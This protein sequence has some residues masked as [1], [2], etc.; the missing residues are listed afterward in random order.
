MTTVEQLAEQTQTQPSGLTIGF[1]EEE[2]LLGARIAKGVPSFDDVLQGKIKNIGTTNFQK[3]RLNNQEYTL[4]E[5]LKLPNGQNILKNKYDSIINQ[6]PEL[7]DPNAPDILFK[8]PRSGEVVVPEKKK[9]FV[10][11]GLDFLGIAS[12]DSKYTDYVEAREYVDNALVGFGIEDELIRQIFVDQYKTGDFFS[13]MDRKLTDVLR[14]PYYIPMLLNTSVSFASSLLDEDPMKKFEETKQQRMEFAVGL[15]QFYEQKLGLVGMTPQGLINSELHEELKERLVKMHGPQ[16]GQE[17]YDSKYTIFDPASKKSTP[18]ELVSAELEQKLSDFAFQELPSNA[19]LLLWTGENSLFGGMIA[20]G[21][22]A[23]QINAAKKIQQV[24]SQGFYGKGANKVTVDAKTMAALSDRQLEM[25]IDIN[26]SSTEFM[27]KFNQYTYKLGDFFGARGKAALGGNELKQIEA[28]D[29]LTDEINQKYEFINNRRLTLNLGGSAARNDGEIRKAYDEIDKLVRLRNA[30]SYA[31]VRFSPMMFSTIKDEMGIAL[32]QTVGYELGSGLLGNYISAESGEVMFALGAA[33][34]TNK[35]VAYPFK[36]LGS[37][38]D[39]MAKGAFSTYGR[40]LL[41]I[42]DDLGPLATLGVGERAILGTSKLSPTKRFNFRGLFVDGKFDEIAEAYYLETKKRLSTRQLQS[43]RHLADLTG[44]MDA[45]DRGQLVDFLQESYELEDKIVKAFPDPL[46]EQARE[47]FK[48]SFATASSMPGF[49]AFQGL[50][51]AR[52]NV[53]D[54]ANFDL[55]G[56]NE[57]IENQDRLIKQ[58]NLASRKL[59]SLAEDGDLDPDNFSIISK[60]VENTQQ[61]SK[62]LTDTFGADSVILKEAVL[63]Y[64]NNVL[65]HPSHVGSQKIEAGL[66]DDVMETLILTS[67]VDASNPVQVIEELRNAHN[68]V[69]SEGYKV[70]KSNQKGITQLLGDQNA[71]TMINIFSEQLLAFRYNEVMARGKLAYREVDVLLK[72]QKT[73]ISPFMDEF[74]TNYVNI[75]KQQ[76]TSH[77]AKEGSFLGGSHGRRLNKIFEKLTGETLRENGFTD[78]RIGQLKMLFSQP[79]VEG[80]MPSDTQLFFALKDPEIAAKMGLENPIDMSI[81][82]SFYE[83]EEMRKHFRDIAAGLTTRNK[84]EASEVAS[85]A[86]SLESILKQNEEIFPELK[87]ARKEYRTEVFIPLDE[88]GLL[89]EI[90][91]NIESTKD[92]MPSFEKLKSIFLDSDRDLPTVNNYK[93]GGSPQFWFNSVVDNLIKVTADNKTVS[94]AKLKDDLQRLLRSFGDKVNEPIGDTTVP[95]YGFDFTRTGEGE[96]SELKYDLLKTLIEHTIYKNWGELRLNAIEDAQRLARPGGVRLPEIQDKKLFRAVSNDLEERMARIQEMFIVPVK[97]TTPDG[98]T[99]IERRK[100]IDLD[101]MLRKE[102]DISKYA[103]FSQQGQE[104]YAK[105]QDE[106]KVFQSSGRLEEKVSSIKREVSQEVLDTFEEVIGLKGMDPSTFYEKFLTNQDP[107]ELQAIKNLLTEGGTVRGIKYE[108]AMDAETFDQAAQYFFIT[109]LL[110]K[111]EYGDSEKIIFGVDGTKSL[112]KTFTKPVQLINEFKRTNIQKISK[113]ILGEEHTEDMNVIFTMIQRSISAENYKNLHNTTL[114][115]IVRPISPNEV[116]SR[117]FNL[118]RGMVSPSYVAAEMLVR[119]ATSNGIDMTKF[120][121]SDG[122]TAKVFKDLMSDPK[123]FDV[124]RIGSILPAL[125][126]FVFTELSMLG[127]NQLPDM[128]DQETY[129]SIYYST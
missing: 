112:T 105:L 109:G 52:I 17:L 49:I 111:G 13:Q 84:P 41:R 10:A 81:N 16:R 29:K 94:K 92:D 46:K 63:R 77:F 69:V 128:V 40:G 120:L 91:K 74:F 68:E 78:E 47:A 79:S 44:E 36:K 50:L 88:K 102:R 5:L 67:K 28:I 86:Q 87:K 97:V 114:G 19:K 33:L 60:F 54:L 116:I 70:L 24:R 30:Q 85:F 106:I 119:I 75:T 57:V 125:Q 101:D 8:E 59:L 71:E 64:Y 42:V 27:K 113:Q 45:A 14:L 108:Q 9:G 83:L 22:V 3:F 90:R 80:Y 66:I 56:V 98:Q 129:N 118:A 121:L 99:V 2:K 31:G 21:Q 7:Q 117:A 89:T 115:G 123:G 6:P 95:T 43:I 104:T 51:T 127:I 122:A 58:L 73:D 37:G 34:G 53:K 107:S 48:E 126:E 4:Q 76:L 39:Y 100:L 72:D 25:L 93:V 82:A 15:R 1:N 65:R 11:K 103:Q 55:K 62:D 61:A 110:K 32:A 20:K 124:Q 26:D 35:L 12:G 23:T 38:I 18:I 96:V